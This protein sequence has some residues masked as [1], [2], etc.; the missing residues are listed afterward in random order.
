MLEYIAHI[1]VSPIN[2]TIL[3]VVLGVLCLKSKKLAPKIGRRIL[4]GAAVW[5]FLCSQYTFSYWLMAPLEDDYPPFKLQDEGWQLAEVY[6]VLG[7]FHYDA[8]ELP[9]ANQFNECSLQRLVHTA[10]MYNIT[11]RP[12]YVTGGKINSMSDATHAQKSKDL[13]VA[14][15]VK[16]DDIIKIETGFNTTDEVTLVT[17]QIPKESIIG[18]I[19]SASH[20]ARIAKQLKNANQ[21]FIF[22]PVHFSI[23]GE[24]S[25]VIHVPSIT[26]LQRSQRAFYEWAAIIRDKWLK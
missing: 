3:L 10:A 16:E 18:V 8:E 23:M 7:C 14:L 24:N 25:F 11:P 22:V 13:L 19:S 1:L 5:I 6:W 17:A 26:A 2:Q 9:L 15:G 20:G 4:A 21:A 12:V